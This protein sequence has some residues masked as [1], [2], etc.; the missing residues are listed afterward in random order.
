MKVPD[1]EQAKKWKEEVM[2]YVKQAQLDKLSQSFLI[3]LR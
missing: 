1:N 2:G 3:R